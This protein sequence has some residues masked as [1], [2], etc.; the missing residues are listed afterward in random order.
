MSSICDGLDHSMLLARKIIGGDTTE[1]VRCLLFKKNDRSLVQQKIHIRFLARQRS[2]DA[3]RR[4]VSRH[5]KSLLSSLNYTIPSP[6]PGFQILLVSCGT[7][8]AMGLTTG[9]AL[10]SVTGTDEQA[11]HAVNLQFLFKWLGPTCRLTEIS[12]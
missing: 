6:S 9:A 11:M 10:H 4:L 1:E 3:K 5:N 2:W 8:T 12:R 7:S